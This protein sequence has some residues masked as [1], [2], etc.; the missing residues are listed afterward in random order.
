MTH[1]GDIEELV[2]TSELNRDAGAEARERLESKRKSRKVL[3][4][5]LTVLTLILITAVS[6][7]GYRVYLEYKKPGVR[8]TDYRT[9][10]YVS[11][12][13]NF[14][15]TGKRKYSYMQKEFFGIQYRESKKVTESTEVDVRGTAMNIVGLS[16][17]AWESVYVGEGERGIQILMPA[18]LYV[19]TIGKK[20]AVFNYADFCK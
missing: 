11:E 9:C 19:I 6:L 13:Q 18:E 20:T 16:E 14:E 15:L 4:T 10:T 17:G 12:E 2:E 1:L 5:V 3:W 7:A 8:V